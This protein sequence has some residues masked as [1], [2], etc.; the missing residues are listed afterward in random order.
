MN[1]LKL[2]NFKAFENSIV[3]P[4]DDSKNLLLFGENGAGKSSIYQ[5]I[6]I[7][8]F[9]DRLE[10]KITAPTPED[11]KQKIEAFWSDYN[12]KITN[13]DFVIEIDDSSHK[14]FQS[15]NHQVFMISLDELTDNSD[16]INLISLLKRFCFNVD[17]ID[18][19]CIGKFQEIEAQVNQNLVLFQEN[20]SIEIDEQDE[21]NI[22]LTDVKKNIERKQELKKYFNE[23]KLNV[24]NLLILLSS[25]DIIKDDGKPK[26]LVLDDFITSLDIS[27]RTFLIKYIFERF[28]DTQ[29]LIFTHNISFYNLIMFMIRQ[30]YSTGEKWVFANLY[31]I[32]NSHKLYIKSEIDLVKNLRDTFNALSETSTAAEIENLGNRVRKKF[33]VLLYE[34]SK[35]L[36]IGTVE[37]S[38]KILDRII[39]GK[40]AFYNAGKT[41]TDLIDSIDDLLSENNPHNLNGRIRAK[42]ERFTNTGLVNFKKTLMDLKLY[43]KVTMH[44]LSHGTS[45][46]TAFTIKE[47]QK[48][49]D[50]LAKM[51]TYLKEMVDNNV[52]TV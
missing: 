35:L 8:F 19:F 5:A 17:D 41:A 13:K 27:N 36:M 18:Q 23:A 40:S 38:K 29:L 33:E 37:D 51:E 32:E 15:T 9:K 12:N 4:L 52:T 6:K 42:I 47:L 7:A 24:I 46:M 22:K 26:M 39:H 25:I 45:G 31:E 20:V 50:L 21:F 2:E 1:K 28:Q 14:T 44:P 48:S 10:D 16:G 49:I 43:Q 11:R 34:Y 3:I 30:I